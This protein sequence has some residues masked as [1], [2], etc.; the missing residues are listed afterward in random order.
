M[1][2]V[3]MKSW[4]DGMGKISLTKL[5]ME[6]LNISLKNAKS[7]VDLLLDDNEIILEIENEF[8]AKEF[9]QKAQSIGVNC[10][11]LE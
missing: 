1:A 5:Q 8:L 7:N 3:I 4:R 2:K 10:K 11:L 6:L 9:F